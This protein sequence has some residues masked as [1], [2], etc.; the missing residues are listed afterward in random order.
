MKKTGFIIL[1]C[2]SICFGVGA[3]GYSH[4]G[5]NQ[6]NPYERYIYRPGVNFHTSIKDYRLEE[7]D[8]IV[9][10][11]SLLYASMG[12]ERKQRNFWQRIFSDDLLAWKDDDIKIAINPLVDFQLGKDSPAGRNTYTNTRGLFIKGNIGRNV[13]FYTDYYENQAAFPQYVEQFIKKNKVVPGQGKSK[14]FGSDANDFASASGYMSVNASKWINV[15]VGFGKNFIGD[16][17][18]SLILSDNSFSYPFLKLTATFWKAKYMI[19]WNQMNWLETANSNDDPYPKKYGVFHYLDWNIGN[20]FTISLF[21]S[22]VW[23]SRDTTGF[24]GFEPAYLNPI[25][26]FR[27]VEYSLGSPDKMLV[28]MNTKYIVAQNLTLYGQL[29]FNEFK[30]DELTSGNNWWANKYG[31]QIGMKSHDIFGVR[32]FDFQTE[33]AQVRPYTYTGY[34]AI[35]NYGHYNQP[36]AHPLGA[37]FRES[38]TIANYRL[39]RWFFRGQLNVAMYGDDTKNVNYGHDIY[40]PSNSRPGDYGHK[41]GQ[42]VK[43]DLLYGD[44]SVSFLIN[45]RN[46]FNIALGARYRKASTADVTQESKQIYFAVRMSLRNHYYD[47]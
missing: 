18:R 24:R 21:E 37:N 36:L 14:R 43:T 20:R 10:T 31:F 40:R 3:Q 33:Y 29:I 4:Y 46:M 12:L 38:V 34:T 32:N 47:F 7:L 11:D 22:V 35:N 16:G 28:G 26:F 23:A 8:K 41:L 45:P 42:G 17:Y 5:N 30:F 9:D 44:A 27:P 39:K 13:H 1:I 19:M 25:L 15:Q 6:F 2:L